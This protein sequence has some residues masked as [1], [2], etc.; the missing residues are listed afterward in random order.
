MSFSIANIDLFLL[1]FMRM[2]GAFLFNPILGRNNVP[3]ILKGAFALLCAFLVTPALD[4]SKVQVNGLVQLTFSCFL[5]LGI[6]LAL[7][8][9]IGGLF[10]VVAVAGELIDWQMGFSMANIYDPAGG[11]SMPVVGSVFNAVL[12]IVFF[13]G[14]AHLSLLRMIADSFRAVAPGTVF[15]TQK[16]AQF[17][18]NMGG[19]LLQLGLRLALPVIAVELVTQFALGILMKAV[20]QI[21]VFTV[22][23]Q[24]QAIIG[25]LMLVIALPIVAALCGKLS[26]YILEKS[27]ELFRLMM[28]S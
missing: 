18:V 24:L 13:A 17:I 9:L 11:I 19:D 15:P 4:A 20:P 3:V 22:G 21:N 2:S 8:V 26:D 7:G 14:N 1:V 25:I 23:I 28:Q 27:A 12:L 6:G 10:A 16:S 5:E